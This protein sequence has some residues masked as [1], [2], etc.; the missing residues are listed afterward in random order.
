ML[1]GTILHILGVIVWVGGTLFIHRSVY[2]ALMVDSKIPNGIE[3]YLIILKR[4]FPWMWIAIVLTIGSGYWIIFSY[5]GG[6][7]LLA[8][9][10]Q[11]MS[12]LG[13]TMLV[14]SIVMHLVPYRGLRAAVESDEIDKAV[15][16]AR[17]LH[18]LMGANLVLGLVTILMAIAGPEIQSVIA[19]L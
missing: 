14:N 18:R 5:Y 15:K 10:I 2:P 13:L 19:Y 6:L 11:I 12:G 17:F 1:A 16:Q 4:F 7:E 9:Y 8:Y 3:I